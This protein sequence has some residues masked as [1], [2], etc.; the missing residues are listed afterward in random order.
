[1]CAPANGCQTDEYVLPADFSHKAVDIRLSGLYNGSRVIPFNASI[2]EARRQ[3]TTLGAAK[4][5]SVT[6]RK[7]RA[8]LE[9][10]GG[11]GIEASGALAEAGA[12][13][14]REERK[15]EGRT[16]VTSTWGIDRTEIGHRDR[17]VLFKET[18]AGT[19][20]R[21][22]L[23]AGHQNG[24]VA[25]PLQ[26]GT[27]LGSSQRVLQETREEGKESQTHGVTS[28]VTLGKDGNALEVVTRP[29]PKTRLRNLV[30]GIAATAATWSE[31]KE[32]LRLWWD[33]RRLR[34]YVWM[35]TPDLTRN[36]CT[37][38]S[39]TGEITRSVRETAI[40]LRDRPAGHAN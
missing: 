8:L 10:M 7:Q 40:L 39:T 4:T 3:H 31:R 9:K 38:G 24:A 33:T 26:S 30:F 34:G 27:V 35:D 23:T 17:T 15:P 37:K 18:E 2:E 20:L 28:V 13:K 11:L 19:D 22:S 25:G 1:V 29:H 32:I 14:I 5:G 36:N 16:A 12:Q 6:R 21:G